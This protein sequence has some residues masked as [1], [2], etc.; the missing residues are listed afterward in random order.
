MP[1]SSNAVRLADVF[2][3]LFEVTQNPEKHPKLHV[4]LQRVIGFDMVDDESKAE[5]RFHRKFPVPK[6]WDFK[7]SPPYNYWIYYMFANISSLNQWRRMRG[8]SE[9]QPRLSLRG[10]GED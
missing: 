1:A 10:A 9:Q 7:Q 2:R 6:L 3:P 8:F 5:R 4:F